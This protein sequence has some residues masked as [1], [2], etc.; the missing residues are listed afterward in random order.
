MPDKYDFYFSIK[1]ISMEIFS[2]DFLFIVLS[3]VPIFDIILRSATCADARTGS[4][5]AM[6]PF[7]HPK[8]LFNSI[9]L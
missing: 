6:L 5:G 3:L 7:L 1:G 9:E 4:T 2:V 8:G